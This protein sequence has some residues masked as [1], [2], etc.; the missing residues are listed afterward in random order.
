MQVLPRCDYQILSIYIGLLLH[1]IGSGGISI[2]EKPAYV[3]STFLSNIFQLYSGMDSVVLRSYS[4]VPRT[5]YDRAG[6]FQRYDRLEPRAMGRYDRVN[7]EIGEVRPGKT[8][9]AARA[10]TCGMKGHELK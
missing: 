1:K 5:W 9:R 6:G 10:R 3:C 7:F 8:G 2:D 4:V